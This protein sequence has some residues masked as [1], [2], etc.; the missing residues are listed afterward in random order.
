MK[1]KAGDLMELR[2]RVVA[3]KKNLLAL[4]PCEHDKAL[5]TLHISES[6]QEDAAEA[7]EEFEALLDKMI[8]AAE[9]TI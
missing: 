7:L 8:A 5:S 2:R 1:I 9:I 4:E 6:L 3:T